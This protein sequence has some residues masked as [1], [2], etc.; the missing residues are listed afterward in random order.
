[1][2]RFIFRY[3]YYIRYASVVSFAFLIC[4]LIIPLFRTSNV[5]HISTNKK[6]FSP[7]TSFTFDVNISSKQQEKITV[8]PKKLGLYLNYHDTYSCPYYT[9][10]V[11]LIAPE[12]NRLAQ[13]CRSFGITLIFNSLVE[14]PSK[15]TKIKNLIE[16]PPLHLDETSPLVQDKCLYEDFD[17]NPIY[18]NGTIHHEILYSTSSDLFVN[19]HS[20]SVH[21]AIEKGLTHI[22]VGGMKCNMWLPPLFEQFS[23]AGIQPIYLYD[24]SDVVF[25]RELQKEKLDTHMDALKHFWKW[26]N[27]KYGMITNHFSLL[28]RPTLRQPLG[29]NTNFDR[30]VEAYLFKEY[31]DPNYL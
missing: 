18:T 8:D 9:D 17:I 14:P 5:K 31:F 23:S 1:M 27:K 25:L 3:R 20:N 30:N 22:I 24:L 7:P 11:D 21:L 15:F 26:I 6:S 2:E 19:N 10:R 13:F 12:I 28:D 4:L 16:N 29:R